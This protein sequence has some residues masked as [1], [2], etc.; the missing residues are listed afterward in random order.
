MPI[1]QL[2]LVDD[3]TSKR[4]LICI[5]SDGLANS[6]AQEAFDLALAGASFEQDISILFDG[7]GSRLLLPGQNAKFLGR[8]EL[9]KALKAFPLYGI[10]KLYITQKDERRFD[11]DI[12]S[13]SQECSALNDEELSA[14]YAGHDIVM[15]F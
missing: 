3:V 9:Q 12:N 11:L 8:K 14:L 6:A 10:S 1:V 4:I 13:L 5:T 7:A 15:R 2:V